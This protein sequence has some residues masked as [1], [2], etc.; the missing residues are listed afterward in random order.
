MNSAVDR[1]MSAL[2]SGREDKCLPE[3]AFPWRWEEALIC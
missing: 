1:A 2:S 3:M